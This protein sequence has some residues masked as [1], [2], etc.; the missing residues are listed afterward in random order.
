[1][2]K[3]EV[4][5][6]FKRIL[7]SAG[8]EARLRGDRRVGTDHLLLALLGEPD[9]TVPV[10]LGVNRHDAL[11]AEAALDVAALE[12]LGIAAFGLWLPE[13]ESTSRR[14]PPLSSGCREVIRDAFNL[15]KANRTGKLSQRDF[16][17]VL[18]AREA[19]DP[20]AELLGALKVDT[21][22]VRERLAELRTQNRT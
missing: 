2:A 15:S 21:H 3:R 14:L 6:L 18:L 4:G 20:A 17:E 19:P 10:D 9:S 7:K 11:A 1:M 13:V 12:V 8:S 5:E 16:L 22:A